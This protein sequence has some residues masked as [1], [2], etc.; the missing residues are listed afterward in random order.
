MSLVSVSL[1]FLTA[2]CTS[3]PLVSRVPNKTYYSYALKKNKAAISRPVNEAQF[4]PDASIIRKHWTNPKELSPQQLARL[5]YT[6]GTAYSVASDL[7]DRNNKKGPATFFEIFVGHTFARELGKNP[8]KEAT[9]PLGSGKSVR[10]TMDF[11]FD[12]GL[13]KAKVH[14]AVKASTRERV[15]QA[16]AHQRLL[17]VAYGV[18]TY[19]S[20]L[21][22]HSE[23]K[24]DLVTR[25]VVEICVPDQ[26]LAYQTLLSKMERIYYLDVPDRYSRLC[27]E[28]PI[29]KLSQ[30]GDFFLETDF[31]L[32]PVKKSLST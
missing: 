1:E 5:S 10:M 3:V 21:V 11:I 29:I 30:F 23:T 25:E 20:I 9:L 22:I 8:S 17:D 19:R 15:V 27:A 14:L 13:G 24:L 18:G 28:Y 32:S 26:W 6:M 2:K 7:F 4:E 31:I 16:W 12:L